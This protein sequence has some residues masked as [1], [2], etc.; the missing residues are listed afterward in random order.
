MGYGVLRSKRSR[1]FFRML[2]LVY[3]KQNSIQVLFPENMTSSF[4]NPGVSILP[5]E[6]REVQHV[7]S[8]RRT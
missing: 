2:L 6:I 8:Q 5:S 7:S 4:L 1:S 3:C